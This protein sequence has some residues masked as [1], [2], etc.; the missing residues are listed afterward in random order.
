MS[1]PIPIPVARHLARLG[2]LLD[3]DST[4]G[5]RRLLASK[6]FPA[7]SIILLNRSM[8]SSII[9]PTHEDGSHGEVHSRGEDKHPDACHFCLTVGKPLSRC[10]KCKS[11]MYCSQECQKADWASTHKILCKQWSKAGGRRQTVRAFM[12][13]V[14]EEEN[15]RHRNLEMCLKIEMNVRNLKCGMNLPAALKMKD[16]AKFAY[17]HEVGAGALNAAV[18]LET[19]W[20]E[21]IQSKLRSVALHGSTLLQP[22]P[23]QDL[24]STL[25]YHQCRI[26]A[27]AFIITDSQHNAIADAYFPLG[28]F[29]NHSCFPSAMAVYLPGGY[30]CIVARHAIQP[31]E[32]ITLPY[33]D[34]LLP[35][36][37][38]R[39]RLKEL[40]G[41]TCRCDRCWDLGSQRWV[42]DVLHQDVGE[43]GRL[44]ELLSD[45]VQDLVE[46]NGM[47]REEWS[48]LADSLFKKFT[49]PVLQT[50][51]DSY[52]SND[53]SFPSPIVVNNFARIADTAHSRSITLFDIYQSFSHLLNLF[54]TTATTSM[55]SLLEPHLHWGNIATP[56]TATL[57]AVRLLAYGTYHPLVAEQ[58]SLLAGCLANAGVFPLVNQISKV[59]PGDTRTVVLA[60]HVEESRKV[61][62][63]FHILPCQALE[64]LTCV[65]NAMKIV[66]VLAD[67]VEGG[68]END[69]IAFK[70]SLDDIVVV[71]DDS[72]MS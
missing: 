57:L 26:H 56:V 28:S 19:F 13:D 34:A 35:P 12:T 63:A 72:M 32:E 9:P 21:S 59:L 64:P 20:K 30:Q 45:V 1:S 5:Y 10:S 25:F 44:I 58:W 48:E 4:V 37:D 61:I 40:Y 39:E 23:S 3:E 60:Q 62:R 43:V 29:I 18:T 51:K 66:A 70:R 38:R 15:V 46:R 11:S 53:P 67:C 14:E 42:D 41:F 17:D 27:N 33:L 54:Q 24:P 2:L 47:V 69:I 31:G 16:A 22:I 52:G 71:G 65:N 49:A 55:A 36:L 6:Q 50:F 7:G 8:G 68:W